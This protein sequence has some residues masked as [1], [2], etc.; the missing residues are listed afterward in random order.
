MKKLIDIPD[1][2]IPRL[3]DEAKKLGRSLKRHMEMKI[4]ETGFAHPTHA[5]L[6]TKKVKGVTTSTGHSPSCPCFSCKP[7]KK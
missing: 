2:Q 5:S 4:L 7:S 6:S 1:D 3:K